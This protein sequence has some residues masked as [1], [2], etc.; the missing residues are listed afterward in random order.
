M[1]SLVPLL[2]NLRYIT[3]RNQ[4]LRILIRKKHRQRRLQRLQKVR[5]WAFG[6]LVHQINSL[7]E[8]IKL[9][10]NLQK[11]KV[12]TCKTLFSLIGPLCTHYFICLNIGF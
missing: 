12:V 10:Q 9:K 5:I 4:H 6:S 8:V 1:T 3:L 11:N 2:I 7:E